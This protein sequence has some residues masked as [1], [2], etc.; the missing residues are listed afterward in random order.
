MA[1]QDP[2]GDLPLQMRPENQDE[3]V[4]PKD[5]GDEPK[6][7]AK[8]PSE[9]RKRKT[10]SD[11]AEST[12]TGQSDDEASATPDDSPYSTPVNESAGTP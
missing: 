6:E 11:K 5:E 9:R 7:P 8:T 2:Y 3:G 1:D 4:L 12:P 10:G